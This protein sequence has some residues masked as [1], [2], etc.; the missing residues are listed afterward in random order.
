[1]RSKCQLPPG[2]GECAASTG[3]ATDLTI[4][5]APALIPVPATSGRL[6]P[7][8][9]KISDDT[10]NRVNCAR[11]SQ[12]PTLKLHQ[13]TQAGPERRP[14]PFNSTVASIELAYSVVTLL[15]L[16]RCTAAADN[17]REVEDYLAGLSVGRPPGREMPDYIAYREAAAVLTRRDAALTTYRDLSFPSWARARSPRRRWLPR[18]VG[19]TPCESQASELASRGSFVLPAI[20]SAVAMEPGPGVVGVARRPL[21]AL[22]IRGSVRGPCWG[23][24]PARRGPTRA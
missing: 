19:I 23:W 9:A 7:L 13:F 17:F 11:A 1:M 15:F 4:V 5:P 14:V 22:A 20:P 21:T 24:R 8:S 6:T 10:D 3:G 2:P 16:A 18:A 12:V